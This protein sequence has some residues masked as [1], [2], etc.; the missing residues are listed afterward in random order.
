LA[1]LDPAIHG[2]PFPGSVAEVLQNRLRLV[3]HGMRVMSDVTNP[4]AREH[5]MTKVQGKGQLIDLKGHV[6]QGN[7][8]SEFLDRRIGSC[9][10]R[11]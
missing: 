8:T 4:L 5:T 1:G 2:F 7:R 6:E 11:A 3:G 9:P 10:I